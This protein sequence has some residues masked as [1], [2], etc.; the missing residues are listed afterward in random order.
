MRSSAAENHMKEMTI[1]LGK[2][3]HLS[4]VASVIP[5]DRRSCALSHK[6]TRHRRER[7]FRF[8]NCRYTLFV[9]IAVFFFCYLYFG[10]LWFSIFVHFFHINYLWTRMLFFV[11]CCIYF[12][13][14]CTHTKCNERCAVTVRRAYVARDPLFVVQCEKQRNQNKKKIIII[15]SAYFIPHFYY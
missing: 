15:I 3:N 13:K 9:F 8:Q 10:L 12:T 1:L 11:V 4:C 7:D 14:S 6:D 5:S 2:C